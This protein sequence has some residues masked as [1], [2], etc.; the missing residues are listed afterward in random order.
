MSNKVS[1]ITTLEETSDN[2]TEEKTIDIIEINKDFDGLISLEKHFINSYIIASES[3]ESYSKGNKVSRR[4]QMIART[5]N[6]INI[7]CLIRWIVLMIKND[8]ETWMALGDT[9]YLLMKPIAP[10]AIFI[11]GTLVSITGRILIQKAESQCKFEAARF[12]I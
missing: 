4:R 12:Y 11:A 1:D 2:E 9:S 10:Q 6:A 3:F 5:C 8:K 7:V